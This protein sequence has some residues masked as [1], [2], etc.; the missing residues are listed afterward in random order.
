M[1]EELRKPIGA[2]LSITI[3]RG[4]WRSNLPKAV[5]D[6][7]GTFISNIN[8]KDLEEVISRVT[9][10]LKGIATHKGSDPAIA[11]EQFVEE[12]RAALAQIV[13][14]PLL[15][16]M[17]GFFERTENKPVESLSELEDQLSSRLVTGVETASGAAFSTFLVHANT[18]PLEEILHDQLA[19]VV[20]RQQF[21]D[22]FAS[23]S[24]S[25]LYVELS[26]LIRSLSLIEDA[27]LYLHIGEVHHSGQVFPAFYIP[28][29]VERA[30]T[31]FKI[32]SDQR[33]Y[34]NKRAMDYVAQ[35]VA[36][37]ES[38]TASASV[39]PERI[40][41]LA[42]D[43]P[44]IRLAQRLI[45]EMAGT[46]NLKAKIDFTEPRDQKVSSA[47]V[48]VTNRLSISLFDR[49]DESMINDYESLVTGIDAW[50]GDAR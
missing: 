48:T 41:Y 4:T 16:R 2:G 30:E 9:A 33:F 23:F 42:A 13:I 40:F 35:G 25:D 1:W 31:S 5:V 50:G 20:V 24:A 45:D 29:R 12:V 10:R 28:I 21:D 32:N 17:E 27:D 8:Q 49:S 7:I 46:F 6:A 34:V 26:D 38:R 37:S 39:L 14:S 36:Q 11:F 47:F 3:S 19:L 43:E 44:P 22:F 18:K 15:D